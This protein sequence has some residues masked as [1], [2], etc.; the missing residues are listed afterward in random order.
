MRDND[1][2]KLRRKRA[3]IHAQLRKLEPL[4]AHQYE[5]L[6]QV[7]RA[8]Q[9]V[10]P[11]LDLPPRKREPHPYFARRELARLVMDIM[12]EASG[13]MPVRAIA[14]RALAMKGCSLPDRRMMK[15]TRTL[16]SQT[17][18]K[19]AERGLVVTVG[20]GKDTRRVLVI[21]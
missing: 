7:E 3:R 19:W 14:A 11:E 13:P 1:I 12:R 6:W 2:T 20:K 16:V 17:M 4:I 18:A 10:A 21:Q 8:I 9:A 15:R 5:E